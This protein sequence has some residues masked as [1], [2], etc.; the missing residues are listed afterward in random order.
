MYIKSPSNLY[1]GKSIREAILKIQLIN[2]LYLKYRNRYLC[3]CVYNIVK[4][5]P[6]LEKIKKFIYIF[7]M[8]LDMDIMRVVML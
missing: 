3:T 6:P 2:L 1:W 4:E 5:P 8:P 7:S